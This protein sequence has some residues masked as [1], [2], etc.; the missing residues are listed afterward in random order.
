MRGACDAVEWKVVQLMADGERRSPTYA[1]LLGLGHL[2]AAEQA[3]EV[4]RVKDRLQKRL[5]RLARRV[6]GDG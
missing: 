4:K 1:A 5:R 6:L 2:P 3:R